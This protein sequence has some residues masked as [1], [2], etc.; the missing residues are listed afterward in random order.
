MRKEIP[1]RMPDGSTNWLQPG[2]RAHLLHTEGKAKD[3]IVHMKDVQVRHD[4]LAN[5]PLPMPEWIQKL[6]PEGGFK[7]GELMVVV[8]AR[9]TGK[10]M[11]AEALMR[12]VQE[13]A[14]G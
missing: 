6:V 12:E 11:F 13:K 7:R 10:S 1:Y 4:A 5:P 8:G 2:S 9:S 14:R 3:L